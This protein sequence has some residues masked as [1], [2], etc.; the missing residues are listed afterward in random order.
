MRSLHGM[1]WLRNQK[2]GCTMNT[3]HGYLLRLATGLFMALPMFG[4]KPKSKNLETLKEVSNGALRPRVVASAVTAHRSFACHRL[5]FRMPP[6]KQPTNKTTGTIANQAQSTGSMIEGSCPGSVVIAGDT[7]W[8]NTPCSPTRPYLP[9]ATS[10]PSPHSASNAPPVL[11]HSCGH[12][13][14]GVVT[15][16]RQ[17]VGYSNCPTGVV[18]QA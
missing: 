7:L 9:T 4:S 10:V 1:H 5:D 6:I 18:A 13:A 11:W 12:L 15:I 16:A 17:V 14:A 3:S 2:G 8:R